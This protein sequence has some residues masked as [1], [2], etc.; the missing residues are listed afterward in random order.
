M[1]LRRIR[2]V[3]LFLFI[4]TVLPAQDF[5]GVPDQYVRWA[6]EAIDAGRWNDALTGLERGADYADL[7]SDIS[8]LLA[9]ARSKT[10]KPLGAVLEALRRAGEARRWN[11]YSPEQALLLEAETLITLRNFS[12]ALGV[13]ARIPANADSAVL[14]LRALRGLPDRDE[15]RRIMAET[16]E[17]YPQDP[18]PARIF[19]EY[20]RGKNP[21]GN[22]Q[23]LLDTVLRRLPYLLEAEPRL[24]F[25]A[26]PFIKD[27]EEARRILGGSRALSGPLPASIPAALSLG[28][29]D[30]A[31]AV[32]ELF[33]P[34]AP[35]AGAPAETLFDRELIENVFS[36]LGDDDSRT[37]LRRKLLRFSGLIAA[38]ADQDGVAESR[39]R[40]QDGVI[41]EYSWDADQDG[42]AE[43]TVFFDAGGVPH[44]AEQTVPPEAPDPA[45]LP[46][47]EEKGNDPAA[48][49]FAIPVRD[50]DR[51]R[52]LIFWERYPGVQYAELEGITYIPPPG[53]FLFSPVRFIALAE[54]AEP[55][56]GYP[57]F[58]P[59]SVRISRRILVSFAKTIR[60]PS[61]EFEGAVE[62]IDL[63]RG[64]PLKAAEILD[65]RPVSVTEF[66][67]GRPL[68]QRIDLDL[69]GRMETLRHFQDQAVEDGAE[70]LPDYK[71]II[72]LSES[73]WN[74]DGLY[75]TGE[76][77]LSDGTVVYSWDID[78]D[79][80]REYSETK[81]GENDESGEK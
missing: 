40:Y 16:L 4:H 24:A 45:V 77:Y 51:T 62:W 46:A 67:R 30:G 58:D 27:R 13:L 26:A 71:K 36:L 9:L 79:G 42:L 39:A 37:L 70:E 74:G 28:L 17:W 57:V 56:L 7:S 20:A 53:D 35:D 48:E 44:W 15:F 60:R 22:D 6:A 33:A 11:R 10:G 50:E 5:G 31:A 75:E 2:A 38:D 25:M 43:L 55:G 72:R 68:T 14:R 21:E 12:A 34:P 78:G 41:R 76:L 52:A 65:G 47:A 63:G 81:I 8:Y 59:R 61:R 19:F 49:G 3:C 29:I 66:N 32:E 18:R 54:G 23:A 73:D 1:D 69:D 80:V 64:I